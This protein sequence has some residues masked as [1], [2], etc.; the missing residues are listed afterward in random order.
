M[1]KEC[2]RIGRDP[3]EIEITLALPA[4]DPDAV[5]GCA[6]LGASRLVMG[7]PG[8]DRKTIDAGLAQLKSELT[9][10]L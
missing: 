4:R 10:R 5:R 9:D 2:A 1:R 3:N 6:K 8:F 7:P